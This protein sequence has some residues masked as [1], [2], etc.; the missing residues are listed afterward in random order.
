MVVISFPHCCDCLLC[1]QMDVGLC[2]CVCVSSKVT[3]LIFALSQSVE[4]TLDDT[5][6]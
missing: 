6:G 1:G 3:R 5:P 4:T 2:V